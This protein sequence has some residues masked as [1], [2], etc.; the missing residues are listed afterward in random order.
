MPQ[1]NPQR[2]Q[3]LAGPAERATCAP[4]P[5]G[6]GT[7]AVSGP[8]EP[9]G[10]AHAAGGS[11][12][13]RTARPVPLLA[14][15]CL[16]FVAVQLVHS[17]PGTTLGWDETIYVSQ[18]TTGVPPS[19]FGPP[20][21][22]GITYL[23]AP[24]T[25]LTSS[26]L[27]L[28]CVLAVLSGIGLYLALH[29]WRPLLP[30]R[31]LVVAGGL[32]AGLWITLFYG[33]RA[34]PNLWVAFAALGAA[35]CF[36]RAMRPSPGR[37]DRI[38]LPGLAAWLGFAAL[39]RPS[40]AAWLALPLGVWALVMLRRRGR[41]ALVVLAVLAGAF[42]LGSAQWVIE[43]YT[44]YGGLAKRLHD[45]SAIQGSMGWNFAVDDHVRSADGLAFCRPC[46]VP[47][48]RPGTG[49]LNGSA[50]ICQF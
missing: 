12:L 13:R 31:V 26:V 24:V 48:R 27:V 25:A 37:P 35:G 21:A 49:R 23:V 6:P 1:P 36:L 8:G 9:S 17:V 38:A 47:W 39:M 10:G 43:A 16:L 44:D 29:V 30:T 4:Y 2:H 45:A 28:R 22:R 15:V 14:A 46:D 33:P 19:G 34:M 41:R 18:V 5:A 40:D 50:N 3:D 20:R 7:V 42:L 11:L 32:F